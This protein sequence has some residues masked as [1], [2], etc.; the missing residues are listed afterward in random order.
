[1]LRMD[2]ATASFYEKNAA[3]LAVEHSLVDHAH[4]EFFGRHPC[5]RSRL[6]G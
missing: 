3:R 4:F 6:V 2:S 1:M 5:F